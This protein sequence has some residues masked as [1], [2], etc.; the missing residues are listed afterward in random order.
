M[1]SQLDD[2]ELTEDATE[3][4]ALYV[5]AFNAG[6][7][8]AVSRLYTDDA[9]AV[10]EPGVVLTSDEHRRHVAEVIARGASM[11][12]ATRDVYVTGDTALLIVDWTLSATDEAGVVEELAGVGVDVLRRGEDGKW[13]YAIDDPYG[14]AK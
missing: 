5:R 1:T 12:A 9:L 2:F 13:R 8:E 3:V 6:D 10:W 14:G 7:V 11:Q 4:T